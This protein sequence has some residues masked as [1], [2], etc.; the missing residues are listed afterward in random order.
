MSQKYL[1]TESVSKTISK[2]NKETKY[3]NIF[4]LE[5]NYIFLNIGNE[6]VHFTKEQLSVRIRVKKTFIL[7]E[8]KF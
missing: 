6:T 2:W 7:Q 1:N 8:K 3:W 5:I 4:N